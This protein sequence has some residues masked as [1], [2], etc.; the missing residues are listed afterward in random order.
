MKG[1]MQIQ[2]MAFMILAVFLFFIL[3]GL[4]FLGVQFKDVKRSV[5]QL[6][7][8]QAISSLRVI[9]DMPELN[10]ESRE[11]LSLDEDKLR[12]M[13]GNF[14][15]YYS[16]FWPVASVK[17]YKLY[18]KFDELV[19]CPALDCNYFKIYDNKQESVK[20]YSTYVS[21]CKKIKETGYVYDKCEIGKLVVGV[22]SK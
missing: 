13:S 2:Q 15:N 16:E 9:A 20:T 5:V 3:V 17:V 8:E 22:I 14:G 1:Q 6:Q 21:I 4:F 12:I 11:S 7:T 10:Y 19:E 18:P